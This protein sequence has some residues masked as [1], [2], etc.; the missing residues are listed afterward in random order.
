MADIHTFV[1][2]DVCVPQ[3]TEAQLEREQ[4]SR[5]ALQTH[6]D[7]VQEKLDQARKERVRKRELCVVAS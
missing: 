1:M 2:T 5:L 7:H 3:A 6:L 4:S